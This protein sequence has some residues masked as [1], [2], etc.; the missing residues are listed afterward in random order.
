MAH[1]QVK[2]IGRLALRASLSAM[3]L[4]VLFFWLI[5]TESA[6]RWSINKAVQLSAGKLTVM[7]VHGSI[8]GPLRIAAISL[9][10]DTRRIE[11]QDV[12]L[13]WTPLALFRRHLEIKQL[14]VNTLKIIEIKPS[15]EPLILPES[16]QLPVT[17]SA[18]VVDIDSLILST[19]GTEQQLRAIRF[20]LEKSAHRYALHLASMA[21]EWGKIQGQSSLGDTRPFNLAAQIKLDHPDE[22]VNLPAYQISAKALGN[23][24]QLQLDVLANT[25]KSELN[26]NAQ[27]TPFATFPLLNAQIK[28]QNIDPSRWRKDFPKALINGVLSLTREG[29]NGLQGQLVMHNTLP[30][31]W[32]QSRLPLRELTGQ[33]SGTLDQLALIGLRLDLADGGTLKGDGSFAEQQ[34]QLS[35]HTQ[36]L[37]PKGLLSTLQAMRLTGDIQLQA[38]VKSQQIKSAMRYQ[39]FGL[40]LNAGYQNNLLDVREV[41]IKSGT[42]GLALHGSLALAGEKT[43]QLAGGLQNFNPA[44]FGR[45][46]VAKINASFS[47]T[48][49][50]AAKPQ[51]T[52]AQLSFAIANSHFRQQPLAGQGSLQLSAAR[53]W[54]SEI[55][56]RLASN[57]IRAQGNLGRAG[58]QLNFSITADQ[59]AAIDPQ[60][61]GQARV[62]GHLTG[63]F[64]AL[65]GEVEADLRKL[66][67][68]KDYRLNHLRITGRLAQGTDG[69]LSLNTTLA[70]LITPQGQLDQASVQVQGSR[71]KQNM[72]LTAK[73][74]NL[75]MK[76]ALAGAWGNTEGWTGQ[77]VHLTNRGPHALTLTAPTKLA[78]TKNRMSLSNAAINFSGA[79]I[80]VHELT[81]QQKQITTRGELSGLPVAYLQ[82]LSTHPFE[83]QT[84][85]T[86]S[87]DW[88]LAITDKING[89]IAIRREQGDI[90]FPGK[91]KP[92][93]GLNQLALDIKAANN[94]VQGKLSVNG[95]QLGSLEAKIQSQ[96]VLHKG[97]WGMANNAPL[98]GDIILATTS[99]ARMQPLLDPTGAFNVDGSLNARVQL[100]GTL[101][102]PKLAGT[103]TGK[104]FNLALPD[105]G[106]RFT[107]GLFHAQLQDQAIRLE[108][109]SL[110]GGSGQLTSQGQL[111]FASGAPPSLQLT[112]TADK[113]T[114]LS[115]PDR[116]LILSGTG[117]LTAAK[118]GLQLTAK[119]KADRGLIELPKGDTPT[120]SRDVVVLNKSTTQKKTA[121]PYPVKFDLELDVGDK[122]FIKGKGLDAQLGGALKLT[123]V[124]DALPRASGSIRVVK[125]TYSAYGQ[126]LQVERGILNF[127]GLIDNPGLNIIAM[128]KN[129]AVEAGVSVAGTAQNPRVTLVSTPNVPD[130][131]K[132]S[133]LVL[134][135]GIHDAS[136]QEF[137]ALQAA[138]GALL[139]TGESV[140]LQQRIAHATGLE[141]VNLKGAGGLENTVLTL[142][143]RLSARTYLSY[144]QA[145][146]GLGSMVKIDYTLTKH[147]SVR[148]QAGQAPA[149]DLFYN[150]S[151]D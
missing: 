109:L 47:A 55:A 11:M 16:L 37:N 71:L 17:L 89:H 15:T 25:L 65:A 81:Y 139:A 58:D 88:Q 128:R 110:R 141:E 76:A 125:G 56:L 67:W 29:E 21:S 44:D 93:L 24:T 30:G 78:L 102:K 2:K 77:I 132:L 126:Q 13:D 138:A 39:G 94:A 105:E 120:P 38:G 142:G 20:G 64:A 8:Y 99:I 97:G 107:D 118:K 91:S 23:L 149:V 69:L 121:P 124:G 52:A 35:L 150:F 40:I 19:Q 116:S 137:G 33:L 27:L 84:D 9:E 36:N 90:T 95:T 60:L 46:P 123:G 63:R 147:L 136:G 66:A 104:D 7:A 43:F 50:L 80:S 140:T 119:L 18:P 122:F 3:L 146:T 145:I 135:H 26:I 57:Q 115:R 148:T 48:G 5:G 61:S 62:K 59:L 108:S 151:F 87:G 86:L 101:A 114:V 53:L 112:I 49:H 92:S 85:L 127:Q 79:H 111:T 83:I 100:A 42:G 113:L 45:Y 6:L 70:G 98:A 130:G 54:N 106:L 22:Q 41:S 82:S 131:E 74:A 51:D 31:A 14:R 10:T 1:P 129:Q 96:L 117:K 134:G 133:W 144:E 103:I 73:N 28:A 12:S 72:Q 75:D 32:D 4:L 143:K 68:S 34:L